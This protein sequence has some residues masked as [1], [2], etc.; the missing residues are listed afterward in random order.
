MR[1]FAEREKEIRR[2]IFERHKFFYNKRTRFSQAAGLF[3]DVSLGVHM[4]LTIV[5]IV[6]LEVEE[7]EVKQQ[8]AEIGA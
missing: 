1:F 8:S 2:S 5:R 3:H 6:R 7:N 4:Q